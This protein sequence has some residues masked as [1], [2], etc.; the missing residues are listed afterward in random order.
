M[1]EP[2]EPGTF[3][4][5]RDRSGRLAFHFH[6][7]V[8]MVILI[9]ARVKNRDK[10]I[11]RFEAFH[12]YPASPWRLNRVCSDKIQDSIS[13]PVLKKEGWQPVDVSKGEVA[14]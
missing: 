8:E 13:S 11:Y 9:T 6:P 5:T 3:L 7:N 4:H 14:K 10:Y 12:Y 1:K 2:F